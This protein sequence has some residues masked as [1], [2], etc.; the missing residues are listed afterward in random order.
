MR[1]STAMNIYNKVYG[2]SLEAE[3]T[4]NGKFVHFMDDIQYAY[5]RFLKAAEL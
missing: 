1:A 3:K 5:S 4:G 2:Y